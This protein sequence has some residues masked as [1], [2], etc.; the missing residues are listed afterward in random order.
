MEKIF[1]DDFKVGDTIRF[2]LTGGGTKDFVL[3][4]E[5]LDNIK[6]YEDDKNQ[7]NFRKVHK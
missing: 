1:Y 5:Q 7:H 2:D 3:E 4:Q 6:K